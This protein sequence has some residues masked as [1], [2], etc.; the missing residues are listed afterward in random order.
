MREWHFFNEYTFLLYLAA[1]G[2]IDEKLDQLRG[3]RDQFKEEQDYDLIVSLTGDDPITNPYAPQ[4]RRVERYMLLRL[5]SK[6]SSL[7][8]Q[9]LARGRSNGAG[10]SANKVDA[11][12]VLAR[13]ESH[14]LAS[15]FVIP[16]TDVAPILA[17]AF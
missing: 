6:P 2:S 10:E 4:F 11:D 12:Q 16:L 17:A 9:R 7:P 13:V 3:W 5:C 1:Q 14:P 15:T 8:I